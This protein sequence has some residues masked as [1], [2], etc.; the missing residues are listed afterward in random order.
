MRIQNGTWVLVADGEKY[1]LLRNHGDADLPDLRVIGH[2]ELDN[3]PTREQGTD[4][5][6]R[7]DDP[8]PGRSAAEETDWK[9]LEKERFAKDL[10]EQLRL[11]ALEGRFRALVL[12]ADPRTLGVLRPLLHKEVE[13]RLEAEIN[14]DLARLPVP[15]IESALGAA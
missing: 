6:G 11:W 9:R 4:R 2:E 5:P 13:S 12:V 10:A 7:F 1:L 8:G 15:E 14:K 3:P